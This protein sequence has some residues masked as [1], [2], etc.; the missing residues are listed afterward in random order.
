MSVVDRESRQKP[1]R[2]TT[3]FLEINRNAIMRHVKDRI[4]FFKVSTSNYYAETLQ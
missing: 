1:R 3:Y 4:N 2:S